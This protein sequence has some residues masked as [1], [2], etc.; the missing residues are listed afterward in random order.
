M[1]NAELTPVPAPE[2]KKQLVLTADINSL[3]SF[4]NANKKAFTNQLAH[5]SEAQADAMF[6]REFSYVVQNIM[7]MSEKTAQYFL[8]IAARNPESLKFAIANV[9]TSGLSVNPSLRLAYLVPRKGGIVFQSSWQGKNQLLHNS[10]FVLKAKAELV[11]SND[12]FDMLNGLTDSYS[13]SYDPFC[14][15]ADRGEIIGGYGVAVLANGQTI[16]EF[17]SKDKLEGLKNISDA[18]EN[19]YAPWKSNGGL[20]IEDMYKKAIFNR[21]YR[22]LP[23][24]SEKMNSVIEAENQYAEFSEYEDVK[25]KKQLFK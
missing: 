14:S 16:V 11:Y 9:A 5:L 2:G 6:N 7:A 22:V 10:G 13:H 12:S 24:F 1:E 3:K 17:V 8:S 21:L 23:K 20:F 19:E 18:K 15:V 4:V 25:P